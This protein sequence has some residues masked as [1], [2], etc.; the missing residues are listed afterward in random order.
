MADFAAYAKADVAAAFGASFVVA[1]FVAAVD[2]AIAQSAGSREISVWSS[3]GKT[4]REFATS[5]VAFFKAPPFR[6]LWVLYGGTYLAA[7]AFT[8]YEECAEA[9]APMAKTSSIFVVNASLSLWKDCGLAKLFGSGPPKPVPMPAYASW[10]SRDFISM[11]VIFT[12]PP[13]IA[14]E[15]H[16][17]YNVDEKTAQV[18]TQLALP[19]LLQPFVAPLHLYGYVKYNDRDASSLVVKQ[20][21]RREILGAVQMRIMRCI[22]P[23]CAGTVLNKYIR[24]SLK[25]KGPSI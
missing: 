10:W 5:P 9:T 4:C 13:I 19:L 12:L 25:P 20:T 14:K 8:S 17:K 6:F 2:T 7:N 1:P 24:G 21:M 11:A 15:L 22:P 18:S 3:L 16:E 23:Y